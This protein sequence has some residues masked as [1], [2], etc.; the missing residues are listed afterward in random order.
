MKI[1]ICWSGT[2]SK[3][4]AAAM[5]NFLEAL[6]LELGLPPE[7]SF[8]PFFS[9]DIGKGLMWMTHLGDQLATA[10]AAIL[11][12]TP[13]NAGSPWMHFEAGAVANH[14]SR[15]GGGGESGKDALQARIFAYLFGMEPRELTGPLAAYQSTV[16]TMEDTQTL[17]R[18]L[19]GG[20]GTD[21]FPKAFADCWTT[22]AEALHAARSQP[23]S[24]VVPGFE[25]KFQGLTFA[26]PLAMC[27]RQ[28]WMDRISSC[29]HVLLELKD[30]Q[31]DVRRRCRPYQFE[32]FRQLLTTLDTYEMTMHAYLITERRFSLSRDGRL[33]MDVN[34]ESVCDAQRR[35]VKDAVAALLDPER[36]P[37]FDEAPAFA[38]LETFD[39]RKKAIH[40]RRTEIR[41]WIAEQ[42]RMKEPAAPDGSCPLRGKDRSEIVRA[43]MSEWDFDRIVY[44]LLHSECVREGLLPGGELVGEGIVQGKELQTAVCGWIDDELQKIRSKADPRQASRIRLYYA[45]DVLKA[46][47][48]RDAIEPGIGAERARSLV[49]DVRKNEEGI[50]GS[51]VAELA[52]RVLESLPSKAGL[53]TNAGQAAFIADGV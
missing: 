28:A 3:Q 5:R 14:F 45:L 20:R 42:K 24:E 41:D 21:Q 33:S 10:D 52:R 8:R 26:E 49:E 43:H 48:E 46:M 19:L 29:R 40:R 31:D 53:A 11:C 22:V 18:Q 44:Y 39:E 37:V 38:G 13:E 6:N 51:Q 47:T 9:E 1:F 50:K 4:V 34:V 15:A 30:Q 12:V 32:L 23:I 17:T 7:T 2:R 36:A 35:A 16:A 25:E 27:H